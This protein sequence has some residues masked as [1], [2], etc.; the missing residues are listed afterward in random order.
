MKISTWTFTIIL[1]TRR[2]FKN[3]GNVE[4]S[5][6]RRTCAL[7]APNY[8]LW[9]KCVKLWQLHLRSQLLNPVFS[10][11]HREWSA[12]HTE[13]HWAHIVH[14]EKLLNK[15]K[16]NCG[17]SMERKWIR[18]E[19]KHI[20]KMASRWILRQIFWP[21]FAIC[22][23]CLIFAICKLR[24]QILLCVKR[25]TLSFVDQLKTTLSPKMKIFSEGEGT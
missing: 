1:I 19:W 9:Q 14:F 6:L 5:I 3:V 23:S 22:W 12:V 4:L 25:I 13:L 17:C 20:C 11:K 2:S 24:T 18:V 15:K 16:M 10:S 21:L 8:Y 7:H